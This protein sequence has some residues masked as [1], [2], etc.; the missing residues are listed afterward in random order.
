M[1][2]NT[3]VTA[4]ADPTT[5]LKTWALR[6]ASAAGLAA[7]VGSPALASWH[8]LTHFGSLIGLTGSWTA[9]VPLSLDAAAFYAA[10]LALRATLAGDSALW[11]RA[12]TVAYALTSAA[13]NA[14]AAP[15]AAAAWFYSLM[16]VSAV[17]LW[18]TTIRMVRRS[19][20]REMGIIQGA[21]ARFRPLRWVLAPGETGSAWK[22]SVLEDIANPR[23]ALCMVRGET[24]GYDH[25]TPPDGGTPQ[26]SE[27]PTTGAE[28]LDY[29]PLAL[30][31]VGT[32]R[33]V[34]IAIF[35]R[36][37]SADVPRALA[38]L[39]DQKIVMD[40]SYAYALAREW[41]PKRSLRAVG[42]GDR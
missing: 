2:A 24:A 10:L 35:E 9:L 26:Q 30:P 18:D 8:G 11:P 7:V 13:F 41:T 38:I 14:Y 5:D 33:D 16:S 27:A 23:T 3:Q 36:L 28:V 12:L 21:S 37:G 6:A 39:A 42:R 22:Y 34:L 19:Q 15:T 32:K 4:P 40:R 1:H 29:Q 17:V 31:P 20:L 25:P